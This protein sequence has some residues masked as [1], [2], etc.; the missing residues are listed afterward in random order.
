MG[1]ASRGARHGLWFLAGVLAWERWREGRPCQP[2]S[3]MGCVAFLYVTVCQIGGWGGGELPSAAA[4]APS[5][6]AVITAPNWW[7]AA[8]FLMGGHHQW[9]HSLH[10]I[11]ATPIMGGHFFWGG[12]AII[13]NV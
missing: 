11:I 6:A 7:V 1:Q 4:L 3:A 9:Q 10:Q 12:D 8:F 13:S 2:R 5:G